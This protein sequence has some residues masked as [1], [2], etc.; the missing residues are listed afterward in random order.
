MTRRVQW[1]EV[2]DWF[3]HKQGDLGDLWHRGIIFPGLLKVVGE[4]TGLDVLDVGCGNGS[5]PRILARQ[6]NR[7]TATDHSAAIIELACVREAK[8]PL[9]VRYLAADAADLPFGPASFDLVTC[10]MALQD[11]DPADRAISEMA[12]V[13]RPR[14]R[15]V[16]CFA[17][18]CFDVPGASSWLIERPAGEAAR[19]SRRVSRYR[20]HFSHWQ[21]WGRGAENQIAFETYHRPLSWYFGVIRAAGMAV[22]ALEEPEPTEEFFPGE[23]DAPW[24]AQFPMHCVIEARCFA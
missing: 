19:V 18:P 17:H 14:G 5:L 24:I 21:V 9:G 8:R 1:T 11:I 23:E 4:V 10:C 6:G 20:E 13:V 22:T 2:A 15:F 12:H 7:V 3:D 16:L